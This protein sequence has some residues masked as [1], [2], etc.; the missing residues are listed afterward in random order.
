MH[1]YSRWSATIVLGFVACATNHVPVRGP[2]VE[3]ASL[4]G[5]W[6]GAYSSVESDRHGD[7]HFTLEVGADTAHGNVVMVPHGDHVARPAIDEPYQTTFDGRFMSQGLAIRF[8]E[9]GGGMVFGELDPYRDPDCGCQLRTTFRGTLNGDVISGT[10][11]SA[12]S[13]DGRVVNGEWRV[14]RGEGG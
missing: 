14:Q 5:D 13:G 9:I 11:R 1:S 8:V 6:H 3:V 2:Q 10:Y 4:A 7:I 12:H